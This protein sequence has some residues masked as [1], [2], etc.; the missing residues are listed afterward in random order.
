MRE[1]EIYHDPLVQEHLSGYLRLF[2]VELRKEIGPDI[3]ISIRCSGPTITD[4]M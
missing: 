3:E 4:Q 1:L 2:L